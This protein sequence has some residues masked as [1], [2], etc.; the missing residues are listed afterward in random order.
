[1]LARIPNLLHGLRV[2]KFVRVSLGLP[3]ALGR[4]LVLAQ[5]ALKLEYIDERSERGSRSLA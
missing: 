2:L 5:L 3:G 4:L 1:M